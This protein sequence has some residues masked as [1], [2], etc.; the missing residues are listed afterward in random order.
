MTEIMEPYYKTFRFEGDGTEYHANNFI[1]GILI[2]PV[3]PDNFWTESLESRSPEHMKHWDGMP[4]ILGEDGFYK[5][6]CLDGGEWDRPTLICGFDN[7]AKT[8]EFLKEKYQ[9]DFNYFCLWS[10]T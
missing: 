1:S 6:Y 5:A 8:I 9:S 7:L 10:N 2:D 4:F 3:L